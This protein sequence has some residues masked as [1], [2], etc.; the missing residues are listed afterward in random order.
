MNKPAAGGPGDMIRRRRRGPALEEALLEAAWDELHAAGYASFTIDAVARRAGTS[1]PVLY[2]RWPNRAQLVLAAIRAHVPSLRPADFPDTGQLRGDLIAELRVMRDRY[3]SV[4]PEIMNGLASELD[5]LPPDVLDVLL[6]VT[7]AIVA[8][9]AS[10]G[11][12]G[13]HPVPAH[14]LVVPQALLR[15]DLGLLHHRPTDAELAQIVDDI[16]IPAIQHA[17]RNRGPS[18]AGER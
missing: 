3:Y 1:R 13:T 16:T 15:H 2:R 6:P 18:H 8:R 5:H 7:S 11:E 9:A 17:S 14:V 4:G 12:I 10:R